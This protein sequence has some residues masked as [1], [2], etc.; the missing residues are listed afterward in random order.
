MQKTEFTNPGDIVLARDTK[1]DAVHK[2]ESHEAR[3][4]AESSL[5]IMEIHE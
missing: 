5:K 1:A 2:Y 3:S 4:L